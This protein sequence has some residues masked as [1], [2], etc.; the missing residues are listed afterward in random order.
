MRVTLYTQTDCAESR[1]VWNLLE[2]LSAQH[3]FDLQEASSPEGAPAPCV[4]FEAPGSPFHRAEGLTQERFLEYLEAARGALPTGDSAPNAR[5][6]RPKRKAGSLPTAE[7]EAAHPVR[8]CLWRHRVGGI[9]GLLSGFVGLA[10]LAPLTPAW[11]WGSGFYG[12]VHRVYRLVCD[13]VPERSAQFGGLP[14]CLCWR[15]TAIYVGA[16]LFGAIYTVGR[17]RRLEWM[18]WL[19]RPVSLGV[20]LLY[21]L[22]LIVDGA[23]HALGLR[24]GIGYAHS[25]DF[26]L[27]WETFSADWWLRIATALLATVGAVRFLCPRLDKLGFAYEQHYRA[28]RQRR[29]HAMDGRVPGVSAPW[30][31]PAD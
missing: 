29:A 12:A 8:S 28:R 17:D 14:V 10:W 3:G 15:C 24:A 13:Q 1:R 5:P 6:A 21:G 27:S 16:L 18:G 4:R 23:S 9:V 26:W 19:V 22:P 25:P 11:G 31:A 7:Y 30:R 20:M 2:H